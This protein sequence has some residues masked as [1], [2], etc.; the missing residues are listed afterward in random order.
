MPSTRSVLCELNTQS[1]LTLYKQINL[2]RDREMKEHRGDG[3]SEEFTPEAVRP[4]PKA[5]PR[6]EENRGKKKR[7]ST[8][9][10]DTPEKEKIKTEKEITYDEKQK[11]KVKKNISDSKRKTKNS[12]KK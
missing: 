11:K 1:Q 10:T 12:Y 5:P 8:I 9:Y 2:H 3:K 7:K 6:K 4:F